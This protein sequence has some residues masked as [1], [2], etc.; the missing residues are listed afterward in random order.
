GEE[1]YEEDIVQPL[2][3]IPGEEFEY[4]KHMVK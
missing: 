3:I 4:K 1:G 2:H